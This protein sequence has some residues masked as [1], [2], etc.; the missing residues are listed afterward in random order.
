MKTNT[1]IY[2]QITDKMIARL[3]KGF[4]PW[5]KPWNNAANGNCNAISHETGKPYSMLNQMLLDF[6]AG[7]WLTWKQIQAEGGRVKNGEKSSLV[8]FWSKVNKIEKEAICDE[9]GDEIGIRD[10]LVGSYMVL[11]SYP[12]FHIDQTEGITPRYNNEPV[13]NDAEPIEAAESVAMNY[14]TREGLKFESKQSDR[15][16]YSPIEDRVCVP[17]LAQYKVTEEYYST[18]FHE[19][20]HSTGAAHRLNRKEVAGVALF[21]DENYSREELVAEM[22]AAF[23]VSTL[24]LD[25][26]KA[27]KNSVAYIQSWLRALK[28]DKKML[29]LAATKAEQAVKYI[30]NGK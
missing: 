3:E 17:A 5:Q 2:Q 10:V 23:L 1:N 6:R 20:T 19:L 30:L 4:I 7:E 21:G 9:N 13:Q 14:V 22:G 25:C 24:G 12:V 26:E 27:F 11:K 18:L 8:V 28:N 15:A 29:V 16:Y